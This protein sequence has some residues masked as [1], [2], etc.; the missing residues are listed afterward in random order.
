ME[1]ERPGVRLD[2]LNQGAAVEMFG[3]ELEKVLTNIT[4][5]NTSATAV[6]EITIKVTFKPN[7]DR[8]VGIVG[9]AAA[10]KL[11]PFKPVQTMV[12]IGMRKGKPTAMENN[13]KQ[14][15]FEQIRPASERAS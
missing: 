11:A 7:E 5:P 2:T 15:A 4:D 13:P 8:E 14:L 9:I 10:S 1:E 6:R 3:R 12:Y